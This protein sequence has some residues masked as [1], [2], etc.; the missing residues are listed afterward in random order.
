ME[1]VPAGDDLG[2]VL[3]QAFRLIGP[4]PGGLDRRLDGLRPRVHGQDHVVARQD[5]ELPGQ[6]RPLI[7][8]EGARGERHPPGLIFQG[9]DDS[10]VAVSLV[11]GRIG[12]QEIQ[13]LA[14]VEV[15]DPDALGLVDDDVQRMVV[16]RAVFIF[17]GD[18]ALGVHEGCSLG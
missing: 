16:V 14:A 17:D 4:L 10:R 2:R 18:E 6:E 9:L 8:A 7:V 15:P 11:H 5:A 1:I 12:A 13:V 3:G